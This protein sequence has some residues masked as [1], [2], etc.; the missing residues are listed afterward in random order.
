ML[1]RILCKAKIKN[2]YYESWKLWKWY[3]GIRIPVY[4]TRSVPIF[5]TGFSFLLFNSPYILCLFSGL[6]F[7]LSPSIPFSFYSVPFKYFF[8]LVALSTKS[9]H[10]RSLRSR[11][12]VGFTGTSRRAKV[13]YEKVTTSPGKGSSMKTFSGGTVNMVPFGLF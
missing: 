10:E 4:F 13:S 2:C 11:K 12:I 6:L 3:Y 9:S 7:H 5:F 1:Y 8:V